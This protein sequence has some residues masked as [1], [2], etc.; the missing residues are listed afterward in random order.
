MNDDNLRAALRPSGWRVGAASFD[1]T[2]I[3]GALLAVTMIGGSGYWVTDLISRDV[4]GVPV[5]MALNG[6]APPPQDIQVAEV[7]PVEPLGSEVAEA[8]EQ[9]LA[10]LEDDIKLD[11]A[12]FTSG[13]LDVT[14]DAAPRRP[15]ETI[16]PPAPLSLGAA[17]ADKIASLTGPDASA[18]P[19]PAPVAGRAIASSPRPVLRPSRGAS[20]PAASAAPLTSEEKTRRAILDALGLDEQA[21]VMTEEGDLVISNIAFTNSTPGGP[22][23]STAREGEFRIMPALAEVNAAVS[24]ALPQEVALASSASH[25]GPADLVCIPK[26]VVESY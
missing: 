1:K 24:G 21:A 22:G 19:K 5:V 11:G 2:H 25:A 13:N 3:A 7:E 9:Q 6:A 26:D 4:S 14:R 8:E 18:D 20:A 23:E 17:E 12:T 15:G 10:A 16:V